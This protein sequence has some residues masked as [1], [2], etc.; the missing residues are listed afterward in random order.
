MGFVG[1]ATA[2]GSASFSFVITL[3][4]WLMIRAP[5]HRVQ[6]HNSAAWVSHYCF[7]CL[8]ASLGTSLIILVRGDYG[9]SG[10]GTCW[11]AKDQIGRDWEV[12]LFYGPSLA[13]AAFSIFVVLR[14]VVDPSSPLSAPDGPQASLRRK[15]ALFTGLY[16]S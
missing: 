15:M 6:M 14:L 4:L 5:L 3:D 13:Y 10:D 16:V 9:P 2:L 11:I 12:F 1:Q 7:W 8:L